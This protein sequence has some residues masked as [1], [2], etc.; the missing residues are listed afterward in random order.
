M[1]KKKVK[2]GVIGCGTICKMT[3]MRN[4]VYKFDILEVVGCSDLIP[5]RS[6][7]MA[8]EYGIRQMTNEEIYNDPEIEVVCNLT[9]P[10]SHFEVSKAAME[11]GKHVYVEKMMSRD[12]DEATELMRIAKENNVM[13]TAAPDTFLGA[14]SQSARKYLDDGVIG[15]P[16]SVHATI[17]AG[18]RPT[19]PFFDLSPDTFFFPLHPGG[20]LPYDLGGYYLHNM[21]NLFGSITRVSGFGGTYTKQFPYSNPRHPKY[22]EMFEVN[23]PTS[24]FGSLEFECG[25]HGTLHIT[26]D[27]ASTRLHTFYATGTDGVLHLG[28]PNGFGGEIFLE[29]VGIEAVE[30]F[31][32]VNGEVRMDDGVDAIRMGG[33]LGEGFAQATKLKLPLLHGYGTSSRGLGLAETAYAI[34]N[35][36]RARIDADMGYHAMEVIHGIIVSGET[37]KTYEMTSRCERPAPIRPSSLSV[38]GQEATLD[39]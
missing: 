10:E 4:M 12:F 29:R 7:A 34:R 5:E 28:D 26:S 19:T 38:T 14:W 23:T 31:S 18:Y 39:D 9:Y 20:G 15:E 21:I 33:Q 35:N 27:A 2:V 16:V 37:G 1:Q 36:R 13:Y 22:Q 17:T 3:Y 30:G 11:H 8:E 32:F 25:V 6:K 24:V